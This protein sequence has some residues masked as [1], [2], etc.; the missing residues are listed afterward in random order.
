MIGEKCGSFRLVL[1]E[2]AA[3]RLR[4]AGP[5]GHRIRVVG[6]V[7]HGVG[8][9][10]QRPLPGLLPDLLKPV[11]DVGFGLGQD[12]QAPFGAVASFSFQVLVGADDADAV[13]TDDLC[14]IAGGLGVGVVGVQ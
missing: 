9:H 5:C 14:L 12:V 11:D 3:E 13:G 8:S 4:A 10:C 6:G 2:A 7:E 1:A